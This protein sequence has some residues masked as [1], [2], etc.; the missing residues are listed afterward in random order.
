MEMHHH[1][2]QKSTTAGN[3]TF[4]LLSFPLGLIYFLLT[5]IGLTAGEKSD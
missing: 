1:T 3:I 2:T 5:V 4:L